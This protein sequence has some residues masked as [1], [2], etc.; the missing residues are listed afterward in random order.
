[1]AQ[2][3][4]HAV[5][6]NPI[7]ELKYVAVFAVLLL[8]IIL[9]ILLNGIFFRPEPVPPAPVQAAAPVAAMAPVAVTPAVTEAA[10][11]TA[12]ASAEAAPASPEAGTAKATPEMTPPVAADLPVV[13][14]PMEVSTPIAGADKPALMPKQ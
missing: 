14:G 5:V 1:M 9:F 11:A 3:D 12:V 8:G 4:D 6:T 10:P 2:H 7:A 13:D